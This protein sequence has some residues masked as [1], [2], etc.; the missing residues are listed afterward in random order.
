MWS[1][2]AENIT[3]DTCDTVPGH[4]QAGVGTSGS[5][6]ER[7]ALLTN[8]SG[9]WLRQRTEVL[10]KVK[11]VNR[12]SLYNQNHFRTL[13]F[14]DATKLSEEKASKKKKKNRSE[15]VRGFLVMGFSNLNPIR[16]HSNM[17]TIIS[18][19]KACIISQF[20][21]VINIFEDTSATFKA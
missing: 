2:H 6:R 14:L 1:N 11:T 20:T 17:L 4:R 19:P 13:S 16:L 3:E 18:K 5:L 21:V 8:C 9:V 10:D 12:F 7:D 15:I